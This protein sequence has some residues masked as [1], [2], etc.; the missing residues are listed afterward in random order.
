MT[1]SGRMDVI[2]EKVLV[3]IDRF[4]LGNVTDVGEADI[5]RIC[6]QPVEETENIVAIKRD[7]NRLAGEGAFGRIELGVELPRLNRR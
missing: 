5:L 3:G 6:R 4:G 2:P 7:G 1:G